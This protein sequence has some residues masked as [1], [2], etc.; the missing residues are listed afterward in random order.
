MY[1]YTYIIYNNYNVLYDV[2]CNAEELGGG[3]VEVRGANFG[4]QQGTVALGSALRPEANLACEVV[5]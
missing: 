4:D 1:T 2:L 5:F 3:E